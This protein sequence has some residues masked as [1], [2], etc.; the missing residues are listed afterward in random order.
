[1]SE[2][3]FVARVGDLFMVNDSHNLFIVTAVD[4]AWNG[5]AHVVDQDGRRPRRI[6]LSAL[7]P[8]RAKHGYTLLERAS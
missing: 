1:M 3:P 5:F 2:Q 6:R 8:S 4:D 7:R